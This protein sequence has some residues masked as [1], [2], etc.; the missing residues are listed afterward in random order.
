MFNNAKNQTGDFKKLNYAWEMWLNGV[1]FLKKYKHFLI[2]LCFGNKN[3]LKESENYCGFVESRIRL[4]SIFTIE[5]DQNLIKYTHTTG[6]VNWIPKELYIKYK[7]YYIKSW[8]IGIETFSELTPIEMEKNIKENY[9]LTKFVENI[10]NKTPYALLQGGN[11][12]IFYYYK[13]PYD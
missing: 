6:K 10:K 8:W 11:V 12:E 3:T 4:E 1:K 9:I 7:K 5:V 13:N 2:L